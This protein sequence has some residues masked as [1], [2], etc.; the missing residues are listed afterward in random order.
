[1][2][3]GFE[4]QGRII[5]SGMVTNTTNWKELFLGSCV[6]ASVGGSAAA[7]RMISTL[8]HALFTYL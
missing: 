2:D 1:M 5:V 3:I 8:R 6:E 7:F 4:L